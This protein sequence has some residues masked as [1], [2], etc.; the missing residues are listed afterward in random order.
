MA[1]ARSDAGGSYTFGASAVLVPPPA[2]PP[3]AAQF[4]QQLA[5][6]IGMLQPSA[7]NINPANNNTAASAE[8]QM[9]AS[10]A[11][12]VW[13]SSRMLAASLH[14]PDAVLNCCGKSVLEL[15]AGCG[16][17]GFSAWRAGTSSVCLTDLEENLPRLRQIAALNGAS[18]ASV[19]VVALDWT[20]P[21]P[22]S[23]ASA[24]FDVVLAADVIFWPNLYEPLL[25]TL[26]AL[27]GSPRV[28][29]CVADRLGRVRDFSRLAHER[30]WAM[31]E[32]PREMDYGGAQH[33]DVSPY[34]PRLFEM[35][36]I[37]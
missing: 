32:V 26:A 36:R 15:G 6:G 3:G 21:L 5:A 25:R 27:P 9:V 16:L 4:Q 8:A 33:V 22:A 14:G 30:G 12:Q 18:A 28:L 20:Q 37:S 29:L 11:D 23:I 17:A 35:L 24:H 7:P 10:T 1:F 13:P 19:R 31:D 2:Y 34:P